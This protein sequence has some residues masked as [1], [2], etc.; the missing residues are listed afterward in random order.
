MLSNKQIKQIKKV[1]AHL[2]HT[3]PKEA[4]LQ[5]RSTKLGT[6]MPD[7]RVALRDLLLNGG[8]GCPTKEAWYYILYPEAQKPTCYCG[9]RLLFKADGTGYRTYCSAQCSYKSEDR[10][11]NIRQKKVELEEDPERAAARKAK[12]AQ[13]SKKNWG[14]EYPQQN[15][16]N[17]R[18]MS[19]TLLSRSEEKVQSTLS[20][21]RATSMDRYGETHFWKA[22]ENRELMSVHQ[23]KVNK[24]PLRKKQRLKRFKSTSKSKF[25]T[26][27]PMQSTVVQERSALT[28]MENRGVSHPSKDPEVLSKILLSK[29]RRKDIE[30]LGNTYKVQGYEGYVLK[31]LEPRLTVIRTGL[32]EVPKFDYHDPVSDKERRYFPDAVFKT[33]LNNDCVLE[34]KSPYTLCYQLDTNVAKFR[35]A[36]RWCKKNGRIFVLA[37]CDNDKNIT[38]LK[39][40]TS[41][42]VRSLAKSF[43]LKVR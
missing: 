17:R 13:T 21:S 14:T 6:M 23:T 5:L 12:Y 43:N 37:V 35:A 28:C 16:V 19:E 11:N 8:R 22:Q 26:D 40:P 32:K 1:T 31:N 29:K 34:V 20:K 30:I 18:R 27:H 7:V 24:D 15:K 10:S 41:K 25:G 42:E 4:N 2:L 3:V 36:V 39:N 33:R 9:G 38:Y